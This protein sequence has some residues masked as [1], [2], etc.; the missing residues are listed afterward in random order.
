MAGKERS[1]FFELFR[2]TGS[3]ARP[4][5]PQTVKKRS[6]Q[7]KAAPEQ[8]RTF[9]VGVSPELAI[10]ASLIMVALLVVSH[11]WGYRRGRAA[12]QEIARAPDTAARYVVADDGDGGGRIAG[13]SGAEL[14]MT[15][16]RQVRAPFYT[17][18]IIGG[19]RLSAAREIRDDLRDLNYRAFVY[20]PSRENGYAVMVGVFEDGDDLK[21]TELRDELISMEYHGSRRFETAYKTQVQDEQGIT[22]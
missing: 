12:G 15:G 6:A 11:V 14:N 7:P 17:V 4:S 1:E 19:I 20:K 22:Q 9:Q 16:G 5:R 10:I 2:Q 8:S 3:P 18:R 13:G 21:L